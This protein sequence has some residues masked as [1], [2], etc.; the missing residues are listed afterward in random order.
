MEKNSK[1]RKTTRDEHI[2]IVEY[3]IANAKNYSL[4]AKEFDC[5]CEQVYFWVKKYKAQVIKG[6]YD[7]RGS[8]RPKMEKWTGQ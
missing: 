3:C 1:P 2:R 6:L 4:A 7:R 5:S 8:K